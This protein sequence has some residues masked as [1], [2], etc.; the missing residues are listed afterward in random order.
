MFKDLGFND[1][2][3]VNLLART[4]LMSK[5][6]D[7]IQES[8]AIRLFSPVRT[9]PAVKQPAHC[10]IQPVLRPPCGI[11]HFAKHLPPEYCFRV[12]LDTRGKMIMAQPKPED[13]T[14]FNQVLKLV[15]QL[16]PEEQEQLRH[17]LNNQSWGQRFDE[18]CNR[19][20]QRRIALDLPRMTE[21]EI[22]GRSESD[23]TR[24]KGAAC[25]K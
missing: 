17:N 8:L 19:I 6:R 16:S 11:A 18:L 10:L 15:D 21:E 12:I 5:L 24:T 3:S 13:K 22:N 25:S 23:P 7:L 20:E 2:E 14:T 4:Q 1:A 9:C